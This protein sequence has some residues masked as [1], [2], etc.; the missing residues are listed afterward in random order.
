MDE[1]VAYPVETYEES[2]EEEPVHYEEP[3]YEE[4]HY[5][6]PHYEESV[7]EEPSVH[8][9]E[10]HHDSHHDEP[11]VHYEEPEEPSVHYEEPS[12]PSVHYE[13]PVHYEPEEPSYHEPED[14]YYGGD[15]HHEESVHEESEE[16]YHYYEPTEDDYVSYVEESE[17]EESYYHHYSEESEESDDDHHYAGHHNNYETVQPYRPQPASPYHPPTTQQSAH[18]PSNVQVHVND[19]ADYDTHSD[20]SKDIVINIFNGVGAPNVSKPIEYT[21]QPGQGQCRPQCPEARYNAGEGTVTVNW[22][23]DDHGCEHYAKPR[24]TVVTLFAPSTQGYTPIDDFDG[25]IVTEW[26]GAS[27]PN[28]GLSFDLDDVLENGR[29]LECDTRYYVSGIYTWYENGRKKWGAPNTAANSLWI[30]C[31]S[32]Y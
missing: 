16:E 22:T 5:E 2:E 27:A 3:V 24:K 21:C 18:L 19:D 28:G 10:S 25:K 13:E 9:E 23:A 26:D 4:P 15:A 1:E 20:D 17:S 29:Q 32:H 31:D 7:H 6:E 14:D 30:P 8:Y 12:E 11:S